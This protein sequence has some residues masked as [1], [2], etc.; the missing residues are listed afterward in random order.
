MQLNG[1]PAC[2]VARSGRSLFVV[3]LRRRSK[4]RPV[5]A[6]HAASRRLTCFLSGLSGA[7]SSSPRPSQQPAL[8]QARP[9]RWRVGSSRLT[10]LDPRL[11]SRSL[12]ERP[13]M[14][15]ENG[16]RRSEYVTNSEAR[17]GSSSGLHLLLIPFLI[18]SRGILHRCLMFGRIKN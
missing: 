4:H 3:H 18:Y 11:A 17:G 9:L 14:G 15:G 13:G 6:Q 8:S 12:P 7:G 1:E 5:E 16:F 2:K 10:S